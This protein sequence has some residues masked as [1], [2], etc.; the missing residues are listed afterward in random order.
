M[1]AESAM[2][3]TVVARSPRSANIVAASSRSSSRRLGGALSTNPLYRPSACLA[4]AGPLSV[5][6]RPVRLARIPPR[7]ATAGG[8]RPRN[9]ELIPGVGLAVA[10]P[11]ALSHLLRQ[12][13]KCR[14]DVL[15]QGQQV[16]GVQQPG[17]LV[18]VDVAI[19]DQPLGI[20]GGQPEQSHRARQ[21]NRTG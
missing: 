10:V 4:T 13:L 3:R 12:P 8:A 9:V 19:G 7:R 5:G 18:A 14:L 1:P 6:A 11:G 2:S 16:V 21:Q 15:R 20:D 17:L